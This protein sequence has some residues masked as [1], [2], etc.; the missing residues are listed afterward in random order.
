M[1]NIKKVDSLPRT[2]QSGDTLLLSTSDGKIRLDDGTNSYPLGGGDS[3]QSDSP[4]GNKTPGGIDYVGRYNIPRSRKH[5][6][7]KGYNYAGSFDY[8]TENEVEVYYT[9]TDSQ[10]SGIKFYTRP[11]TSHD[12]PTQL[13]EFNNEYSLNSSLGTSSYSHY[14][15]IWDNKIVC[16]TAQYPMGNGTTTYPRCQN[17]HVSVSTISPSGVYSTL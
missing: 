14:I 8:D 13:C 12:A 4:Y 1:L 2:V 6:Y 10:K 9:F 3:S 15:V 7:C 16:V 17:W 11:Y 5:P